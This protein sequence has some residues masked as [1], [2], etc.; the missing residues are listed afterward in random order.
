MTT[1]LSLDDRGVAAAIALPGVAATAQ[2][3]TPPAPRLIGADGTG[4]S[5]VPER[6]P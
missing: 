6:K 2:T 1:M 5:D 3:S 4:M